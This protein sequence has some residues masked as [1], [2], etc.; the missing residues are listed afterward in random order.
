ML[1]R[2]ERSTTFQKTLRDAGFLD[3]RIGILSEGY[4][5][6]KEAYTLE[7]IYDGTQQDASSSDD[8]GVVVKLT[9]QGYVILFTNDMGFFTEQ[10]VLEKRLDLRC[11]LLVCGKHEQQHSPHEALIQVARPKVVLATSFRPD[12]SQRRNYTWRKMLDKYQ[13]KLLNQ[14]DCGAVSVRLRDGKLVL[15]PMLGE[16]VVI[17]K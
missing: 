4:R 16:E 8:K 14:S 6:R 5:K 10:H 17:E 7:I 12:L 13:V 15:I 1:P 3:E 2:V 11:D 9:W